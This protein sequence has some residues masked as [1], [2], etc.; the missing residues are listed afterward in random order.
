MG[1]AGFGKGFIDRQLGLHDRVVGRG[2]DS[3]DTVRDQ[4]L[5]G[6]RNFIDARAGA[7]NDLDT[8]VFQICLCAFNGACGGVLTEV[9]EKTDLLKVRV[10]D[11]HEVHHGCGIQVVGRAGEVA[12]RSFQRIDQ[13]DG[14]GVRD[15]GEDDGRAGF[16][17]CRLHCHRDRRCNRDKQVRV[18]CL[19]V[20][21]DLGHQIGVCVA[22]VVFHVERY[23]L[24]CSDV[25]KLR[26]DVFNDLV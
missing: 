23:A 10:L 16:L 22:V 4:R 3:L 9:I 20:R 13:T 2:E 21:D 15:G 12:A 26:L 7:L 11:K 17:G 5:R 8:L 1:D 18:V 14:D 19:E 24:F 6:K 25:S